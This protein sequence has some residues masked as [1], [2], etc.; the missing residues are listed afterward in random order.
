METVL[1]YIKGILH[2]IDMPLMAFIFFYSIR[3]R[4]EEAEA[5]KAET[6]N[7]TSYAAEWKELYE[8]KEAKVHELDAKIDK[9]YL[10]KEEDRKHMREIMEQNQEYAL[11]NKELEILKCKKRGC[12]DRQPPS[13]Y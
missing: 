10:E 6:D 7:I 8:K 13:E 2:S 9:L 11:K 3:K 5:R 4:K 1:D 12:Q